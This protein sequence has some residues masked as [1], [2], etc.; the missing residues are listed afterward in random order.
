MIKLP[1]GDDVVELFKETLL[2]FSRAGQDFKC[3]DGQEDPR[4]GA[5]ARQVAQPDLDCVRPQGKGVDYTTVIS[6]VDDMVALLKEE[7]RDD[8]LKE[9]FDK[10]EDEAKAVA[11]EITGQGHAVNDRT[12]CW[13]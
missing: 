9:S 3:R 7:Q 4:H 12:P 1:N 13:H 11:R 10:T 6:M 2:P 5:R 8:D